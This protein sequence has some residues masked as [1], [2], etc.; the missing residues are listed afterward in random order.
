MGSLEGRTALALG[1]LAALGTGLSLLPRPGAVLLVPAALALLAASPDP[2]RLLLLLGATL[3][4]VWAG[5]RWE[6]RGLWWA[7]WV[8]GAGLVLELSHLTGALIA[9]A[10]AGSPLPWAILTEASVAGLFLVLSPQLRPAW[11]ALAGTLRR[12]LDRL[13]QG[14][15]GAAVWG[16]L[17]G[18]LLTLQDRLGQWP[19]ALLL[20]GMLAAVL[21]LGLVR[22]PLRSARLLHWLLG[23]GLLTALAAPALLG[24]LFV[25]DS[26]HPIPLLSGWLAWS[27]A[28]AALWWATAGRRPATTPPLLP[29]PAWGRLLLGGLLAQSLGGLLALTLG[30][31]LTGLAAGLLSTA[32]LLATGLLGLTWAYRAGLR[33]VWWLGLGFFG[34]GVAKLVLADLDG[35]GLSARGLGLT[36][37]GLLLGIGQL[38]PDGA[39]EP[40][41]NEAES[42]TAEH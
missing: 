13:A 29:L 28:T 17:L 32:L 21:P 39:R 26:A 27:A 3:L 42:S 24:D 7:L 30:L 35:L 22:L 12:P 15:E 31:P 25:A 6:G 37:V 2:L 33:P 14:L 4:A 1:A 9:G 34:L 11:T 38:A 19:T 36:L 40:Q 20:T 10:G 23:A 41:G 5:P 8:A 16:W 18:T